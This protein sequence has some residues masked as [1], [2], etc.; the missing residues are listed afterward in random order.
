MTLCSNNGALTAMR[1]MIDERPAV[2]KER[3]M[4][5]GKAPLHYLC[6][7]SEVT[8]LKFK[9]LSEAHIDAVHERD[10]VGK[11]PL[12]Y[13][14]PHF[15]NLKLLNDMLDL[16]TAAEMKACSTEAEIKTAVRHKQEL[17]QK[18][19][20]AIKDI[21]NAEVRKKT[22]SLQEKM[23][24]DLKKNAAADASLPSFKELKEYSKAQQKRLFDVLESVMNKYS[25]TD[26]S[27][28]APLESIQKLPELEKKVAQRE[29]PAT[30][31]KEE[32]KVKFQ[33]GEATWTEDSFRLQMSN[34]AEYFNKIA[35]TLEEICTEFEIDNS[36]GRYSKEFRSAVFR[37]NKKT[38][39]W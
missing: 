22:T 20:A 17:T 4:M 13:L 2:A 11:T 21:V 18:N 16:L 33:L 30:L 27:R 24:E 6:A 36:D 28:Y 34:L 15:A 31:E 38:T 10:L 35:A 5:N 3:H 23:F 12:D 37:L 14:P 26:P 9:V 25:T 7:S 32:E 8:L 39:T 19:R 29:A 1:Q